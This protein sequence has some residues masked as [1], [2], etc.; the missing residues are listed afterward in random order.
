MTITENLTVLFDQHL[1]DDPIDVVRKLVE[2]IQDIDRHDCLHYLA[3]IKFLAN[4]QSYPS[5][6]K[7]GTKLVQFTYDCMFLYAPNLR[8][9]QTRASRF[10]KT[11][12]N[13]VSGRALQYHPA[14]N[15]SIKG[16][17]RRD[18]ASSQC[19]ASSGSRVET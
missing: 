19:S 16:V 13:L 14:T 4:D 6:V 11:Q 10:V 3:C 2:S 12:A 15:L 9:L 18:S 5:W 1:P 17:E 8:S 7:D